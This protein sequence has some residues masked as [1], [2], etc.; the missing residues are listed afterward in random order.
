MLG[1]AG[2]E[3]RDGPGAELAEAFLVGRHDT[4]A[5]PFGKVRHQTLHGDRERKADD[6]QHRLAPGQRHADGGEGVFHRGKDVVL[7]VD[8]RA[9]H[10]EDDEPEIGRH[11]SSAK[12]SAGTSASDHPSVFHVRFMWSGNGA[13]RVM[14]LPLIGWSKLIERAWR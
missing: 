8:Q 4:R 11:V 12:G 1:G 6:R 2:K 9:V 7:A 10:V 14:R 13:V 5:R 3:R